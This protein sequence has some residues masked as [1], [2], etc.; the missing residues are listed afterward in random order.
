MK[1]QKGEEGEAN[2]RGKLTEWK[3]KESGD[4]GRN[5]TVAMDGIKGYS[6]EAELR[7]CKWA[8]KETHKR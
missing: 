7:K 2:H 3:K 6:R 8:W 5:N 1:E 4:K